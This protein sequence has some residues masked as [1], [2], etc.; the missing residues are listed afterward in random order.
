MPLE[1]IAR[2]GYAARG[3]V[4]LILGYFCAFAAYASSRPLDSNDAFRSMLS[5][6]LGGILLGTIGAGLFCFAVW[7]LAQALLDVD[8][9]GSDLK[10]AGKR[11]VYVF[12]GLFYLSFGSLALSVLLGLDRGNSDTAARDW[13]VWLL[14]MPFGRWLMALLGLTIIGIGVGTAVAGVRAEFS[15]RISLPAES[16]RVVVSL[17]V[18]GY[19]TRALVF[20]MVGSFFA[21]AAIH[22]NAQEAVGVAGTLRVIQGLTYGTTLLGLTAAGLLAFGAF[23]IAEAVYR[24]IPAR[25]SGEARW[26][27]I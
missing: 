7:R 5:K 22:V 17:G 14:S 26:R 13:S 23:G 9:C 18:F 15:H 1:Q 16:R 21:F 4:F 10:G 6:P 25:P 19:L 12:A 24:R 11:L 3:T 2:L 8:G 27:P 20:T